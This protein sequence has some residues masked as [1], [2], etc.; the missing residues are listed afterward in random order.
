M[1]IQLPNGTVTVNLPNT[2]AIVQNTVNNAT[3]QINTA[4]SA[5]LNSASFARALVL[6]GQTLAR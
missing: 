4:L 5:A 6:S 2:A 1:T 3:I